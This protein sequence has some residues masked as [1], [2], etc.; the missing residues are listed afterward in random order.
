M[1]FVL[2][3]EVA[4]KIWKEYEA[5]ILVKEI[6]FDL[7]FFLANMQQIE[8]NWNIFC[9]HENLIWFGVVCFDVAK[10]LWKKFEEQIQ[11]KEIWFD[12]DFFSKPPKNLG[13]F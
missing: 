5:Q 1:L 9:D 10:K 7:D 11:V 3:T 13:I 4:K 12:L 2:R 6:W 8:K